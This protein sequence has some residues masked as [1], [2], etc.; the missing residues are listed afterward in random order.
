MAFI[1][2]QI[3]EYTFGQTVNMA[4][5]SVIHYL[6]TDRLSAGVIFALVP[7][8]LLVMGLRA[9][10]RRIRQGKKAVPIGEDAA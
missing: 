2:G 6:L 5:G 7:L 9:R 3:L 8:T 1:L 4:D 10:K